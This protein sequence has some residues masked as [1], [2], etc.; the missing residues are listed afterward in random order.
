[1]ISKSKIQKYWIIDSGA[2]EHI[3][4]DTNSS[5]TIR[6]GDSNPIKQVGDVHFPN[7]FKLKNVLNDICSRNLIGTG[8]ECGRFY[9][10]DSF[11]E[12][13]VA[14]AILSKEM[15]WNRRLGH[16]SE[17]VLR[18]LQQIDVGN[19]NQFCNP[20]LRAKQTK[21]PFPISFSK[22]IEGFD[23]IHVDLGSY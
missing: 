19:C 13:K 17:G 20:C 12:S 14:M 16:A 18:K 4:P 23:L 21:L 6:N 22:T 1:M 3:I 7:G 2:N 8:N 9:Y 11:K 5:V 10:M 15:I